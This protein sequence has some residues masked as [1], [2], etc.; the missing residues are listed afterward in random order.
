MALTDDAHN[1]VR[2]HFANK[3]KRVAVDATC[4]NGFDTEFLVELGFLKVHAFDIQNAAL[5]NT[6]NRLSDKTA[7]IVELHLASHERITEFVHD[8]IDCIMFNFGYLPGGD[9]N[10]TTNADTS[11]KALSRVSKLSLIHI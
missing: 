6:K 8:K 11:I 1:L 5:S 3:A 2:T 7:K 10:I 4:G 9:K